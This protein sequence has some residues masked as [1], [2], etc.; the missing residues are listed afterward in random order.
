MI[1]YAI[2]DPS[3]LDFHTLDQDLAHFSQK[4]EMILY[5]DKQEKNYHYYAKQFIIHAKSFSF[6]KVLLHAKVDLAVQ[7]G[8]DG[9]HLMSTQFDEIPR[10]KAMGLFVIISTHSAKEIAKAIL[11]DADMV[12][13]SPIF[14]SPN[15]GIPK[16]VGVL[17]ELV[18]QYSIPIIAL[19]GILSSQE[20]AQCKKSGARGFA[21]IRY[22]GH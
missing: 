14:A 16:G 19:G 11:L 12:T 20:I 7:L 10:A 21:S 5:R 9:V 8:A 2:T 3:T 6:D 1:A 17:K 15:K 18:S 4:A 13:L 22:F